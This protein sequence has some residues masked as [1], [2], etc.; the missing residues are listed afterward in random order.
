M[1]IWY[2]LK[3]VI[4]VLAA[5]LVLTSSSVRADDLT[6]RVRRY[7]QAIEYDYIAWTLNATLQKLGESNL[8]PSNNLPPEMQEQVVLKYFTLIRQLEITRAQIQS[9]YS[10][11]AVE[12]KQAAA[13]DLLTQQTQLEEAI[14]EITPLAESILQY[15]VKTV[16]EEQGLGFLYQALPPVLFHS[17]PLPQALIVSPRDVIRQDVDIS[18]LADLSLQDITALEDKVS[19]ALDVSTLVVNVGGIGAYPTMVERYSDMQWTIDTIAHEWTH[20][21]LTFHPLG[22]NYETTPELRTMNET[23]ASI[24]GGEI[25]SLVLKRFYPDLVLESDSSKYLASLALPK[26]VFDFRHEMHLTRVRVD[27]LLSEGKVD[28]AEA[29]MEQRRQVFVRNGYMIRKLNQA[30]F[31]FY[32]AYAETPGGAAGEDPVGPAVRELRSRSASLAEFLR[33]IAAMNS[34]EDLQNAVK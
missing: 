27:A 21:Y 5:V 16:L 20:N 29:Y 30:Y 17:S 34:F 12:D 8:S 23:T 22:L 32:G 19:N 6:A 3:R 33:N 15:Q 24:V 14:L 11:P 13:G 18:L 28:E 2:V 10:D 4:L 1:K 25:S 7:T 26:Q 31:A 9:I